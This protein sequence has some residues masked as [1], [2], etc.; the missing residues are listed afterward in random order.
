M[1]TNF[2][3]IEFSKMNALFI[4][5]GG[6]HLLYLS[7]SYYGSNIMLVSIMNIDTISYNRAMYMCFFLSSNADDR[8]LSY[9]TYIF[10]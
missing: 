10:I 9:N 1:S 2:I 7:N 6:K 3:H 5:R 4:K 8:N